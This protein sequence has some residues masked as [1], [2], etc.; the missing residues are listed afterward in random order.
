MDEINKFKKINGNITYTNKELIGAIHVK[1]D[2]IEYRLQKGD[3]SF[4]KI[5]TDVKWHK[6]FILGLYGS[7]IAIFTI[8]LKLTGVI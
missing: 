1:L 7:L 2:R 8:V 3:K 6:R 4:V 5:Q